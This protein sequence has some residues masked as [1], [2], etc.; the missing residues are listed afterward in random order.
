[1]KLKLLTSAVALAVA[2]FAHADTG[3]Y[4][5]PGISSEALVFTAE[6]DLWKTSPGGGRAQRLT[7][8]AAAETHAAISPDGKWLAFSAAYDGPTEVYLSSIDGGLPQRLSYDN[9]RSTVLGWTPSG[10]ILYSTH[11]ERG[12][13]R[14]QVIVSLNPKTRARTVMPLADANEATLSADGK[15]LYFTRFGLHLTGD[16]ARQYRG[17]TMGQ[18]WRWDVGSTREAER[19]LADVD[20]QV[21]RPMWWQDRLYFVSDIDGIDNIWSMRADGS[22]RKQH[23][24][25]KHFALQGAQLGAGR[26]VYQLGADLRVLDLTS[27]QDRQL[28]I[29]LVSD[30][31]QQRERWVKPQ[32]YITH[33]SLSPSGERVTVTARGNLV[34]AGTGSERRVEIALPDGARVRNATLSPDGKSVYAIADISGEN[35]IWQFATDGSTTRKQLTR[36][37]SIH[38]WNLSLSPDGKSIVHDDKKGQLWLLDIASGRNE[39]IDDGRNGGANSYDAMVWSPD[40]KALALVR[41][42]SARGLDQ[43]LLY[44]LGAR[45]LHVVTSDRYQSYSPAFSRDGK[46]LYF[47]SDRHFNA[48]PSSPWGDRNMGPAFDKRTRIYALALQAENLFPFQPKDELGNGN[49]PAGKPEDKPAGGKSAADDEVKDS[50]AGSDAAAPG[51]DKT[52]SKKLP[53]IQWQGLASRLHEVPLS[54][55]N[56]RDLSVDDKRLYF[57]E[58]DDSD[59]RKQHLKTLAID[60]DGSKPD[61]FASEI[62]GYELS[63]NGKK[64]LFGKGGENG[65]GPLY[66]VDAG[67][68]A[69]GDL[70]KSQV[71]LNDWTFAIDPK[72]EWQQMFA[73]AWRMQRDFLFDPGMRGVDWTAVRKKYEVFVPRITDRAEL[74]DLLSQM[75]AEVSVLHSQVRGGELRE[76]SDA[77]K[78][79][80]LGAVLDR[81]ADGYRIAHI[82]R[83]ENELPGERGPLAQPGVNARVGDIITSVN[84]RAV[85]EAAD[86]AELLQNRAGQQVLLTLKRGTQTLK[87]VVTPVDAG[88]HANLRYSDWE[89]GLRAKVDTVGKGRIGYLHLRAMTPADV[90]TFVRE[91]YANYDREGLIIDVR[92][93]GGG[94]TDSW[95]IEKLLRRAW[96]F[97]QPAYGKPYWN[98]QQTFRGHL[99]VLTDEMTYSDGETF[100]A[101]I[102]SLNLGPL[103]GKRTAG[104]GVWLSD[105]NRLVDG[106]I[107]RAAETPQFGA[108]GRW[109]VEGRGVAPDME[110]DNLPYATFNGGDAQLDAAINY[111]QKKI[112]E[113]PVVQPKPAPIRPV[114]QMA[115][116]VR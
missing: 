21:R 45:Q 52:D 41:A 34:I 90:T 114:G 1:M 37:A 5:F 42:D 67:A 58:Q 76:D 65:A 22:D 112:S 50:N 44:D 92:R 43:V 89:E 11:A 78:A 8:H 27:D 53:P 71:R 25:H 80:S 84:G 61:V 19:L 86:I 14:T 62:S 106:G 24:S 81:Q 99:A 6:G 47:L 15:T 28:S 4:R 23:T 12:P 91:F 77:P 102:K 87:T 115:D 105:R 17:G 110:V 116:D 16:N 35:E 73:D 96:A 69:P 103:I 10:D 83:T 70:G 31:E 3:Y 85:S 7:T 32:R 36:D 51:K 68:K 54:P 100:S 56:Y 20:A 72:Q 13:A 74:D 55:G 46:W 101:G 40:S 108:D 98:Q 97:W 111:L 63:A 75:V 94:N 79:A 48:N 104:A 26:I 107:M 29:D 9:G 33:S 49:A 57:I 2:S 95:L 60:N 38:R 88:R 30:F 18:I 59:R 113:Q 93:N 64:V 39:K 66:I 109:I 82:Y